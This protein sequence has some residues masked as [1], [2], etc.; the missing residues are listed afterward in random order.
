VGLEN[1]KRKLQVGKVGLGVGEINIWM[2]NKTGTWKL[3][4]TIG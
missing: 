2:K 3:E 1:D 4:N